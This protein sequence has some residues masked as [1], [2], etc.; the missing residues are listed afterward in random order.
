MSFRLDLPLPPSVNGM[1]RNV[2]GRGRVA[3][4]AL[5][6]WKFDAAWEITLQDAVPIRVPYN[7]ALYLPPK[8]RGDIDNRVKGVSDIL[9]A[10]GL[11]PDDRHAQRVSSERSEDVKPGRCLVVVEAAP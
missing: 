3:T 5:K 11:I 9:V 7:L 10:F 6:Q 2:R 4:K 8:M 1:Y